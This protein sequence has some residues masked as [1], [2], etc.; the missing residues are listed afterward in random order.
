MTWVSTFPNLLV[1]MVVMVGCLW[2]Y[3]RNSSDTTPAPATT[4]EPFNPQQWNHVPGRTCQ[5]DF[6]PNCYS[7]WFT[8][9]LA[10]ENSTL[11]FTDQHRCN[12]VMNY[13]FDPIQPPISSCQTVPL[14]GPPLTPEQNAVNN[15]AGQLNSNEQTILRDMSKQGVQIM[16]TYNK[17]CHEICDKQPNCQSTLLVPS[18][19]TKYNNQTRQVE[20]QY[21]YDCHHCTQ[22]PSVSSSGQVWSRADGMKSLERLS[23]SVPRAKPDFPGCQGAPNPTECQNQAQT[24]YGQRL[25]TLLQ[26]RPFNPPIFP[27]TSRRLTD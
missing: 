17:I 5:T 4:V 6:I 1:W 3:Y 26:G 11:S 18:I 22:P 19:Q 9:T 12:L 23:R 7:D 14:S 13:T 16:D 15:K 27:V 10:G 24:Q 20:G 21:H 8:P 2:I 25:T